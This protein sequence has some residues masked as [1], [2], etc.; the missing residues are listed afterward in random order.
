M[1]GPTERE[2][3]AAWIGL[4]RRDL[5]A[6]GRLLDSPDP[7]VE[8]ASFHQQQAVEK[9]VK[10]LLLASGQRPR[11]TH[12]IG[13]LVAALPAGQPFRN[14]LDE[15]AEMSAYAWVFRYPADLLSDTVLPPSPE[16]A[17]RRQVQLGRLADDIESWLRSQALLP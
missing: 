7:M 4:V 12:D 6:A 13:A 2:A 14:R 15:L 17:A 5:E 3:I 10:A 16:A 11:F 1:S 8:A 9:M